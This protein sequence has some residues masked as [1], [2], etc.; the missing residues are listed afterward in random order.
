MFG[1]RDVFQYLECKTCGCLQ[2]LNPPSDMTPYYPS[3]YEAFCSNERSGGVFQSVRRRL[4]KR[5]NHGC[6]AGQNWFDRLLAD[7]Y[8]YAQLRAFGRM[9]VSKKARILDVGCG[10][11]R[12][13]A[14]LREL[15]YENVLGVDRFIPQSIDLGAGVRVV[16]GVVEDLAEADWDV[17]MFHHSFEHMPNPAGVLQRAVNLLAPGGH[18]LIRIPVVAWAWEHYGVNWAQLDAPRHLYLHSEKSVRLLA[19][20]V[21]L[22]VLS[23][24]YDSNE[25]Q[26]WASELYSQDVS[27]ASVGMTPPPKLFSESTMRVFPVA[28]RQTKFGGSRRFCRF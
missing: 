24:G 21:G 25:C 7:R 3:S 2:L 20:A 1:F 5:R 17:V 28:C 10:S 13:L 12:F 18:C 8:V 16:K 27:L 23:V 9:D 22:E 15:G 19:C 6:I 11:G 4:R 14:D 26:F